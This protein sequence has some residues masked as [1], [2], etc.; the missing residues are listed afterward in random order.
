M[1][2]Y[3]NSKNSVEADAPIRQP[4]EMVSKPAH[5]AA[6][7]KQSK[8]Q[9]EERAAK[10]AANPNYKPRGL[11]NPANRNMKGRPKSIVNKVTEY[12]SLFNTLNQ[13]RID[14]G[15][16]PL[17]TAMEVLIQAMQSEE[18]DLKEKAKIAEK[19]A[20]FESS[21][22][23]AITIEHQQKVIEEKETTSA[24]DKMAKFLQSLERNL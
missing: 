4:D 21:R 19:L 12:G 14:A 8:K 16:P 18:I 5:L 10:A 3:A 22:A 9:S 11:N 15:L 6:A 1:R 24:E 17:K 13:E 23:P 20:T 7:K 2:I